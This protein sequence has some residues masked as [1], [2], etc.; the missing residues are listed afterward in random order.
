M[1]SIWLRLYRFFPHFISVPVLGVGLWKVLLVV[2]CP[3]ALAKMAIS[4]VQLVAACENY[5][6]MDR[7]ERESLST[8]GKKE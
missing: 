3:L 5:A 6:I 8:S 2:T 4:G 1:S 7:A